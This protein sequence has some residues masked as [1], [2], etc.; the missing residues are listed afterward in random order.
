MARTVVGLD[1]GNHTVRAV[2]L[3]REGGRHTVVATAAV[4]RR[5]EAL[6]PRPMAVVLGEL[7]SLLPLG[8][9]QPVVAASDIPALVRY[10]STVPLPPD[11]LQRLLR[12]E[13][14]Q[15][16]DGAELAADTYALPVPGDE[17]IHCC[18]LAQPLQVHA[19]LADMKSAGIT[20]R[21][22]HFGTL[23]L[24]NATLPAPPVEG[25]ALAL[26]VDIGATS[27]GVVLCGERRL[28]ACRQL[29]F[30]GD[31]FTEALATAQGL[32]PASAEALKLGHQA[33]QVVPS[34]AAPGRLLEEVHGDDDMIVLDESESLFSDSPAAAAPRAVAPAAASPAA[35]T[36]ALLFEDE[37]P[38]PAPAIPVGAGRF[39]EHVIAIAEDVP[40]PAAPAVPA[41]E[42]APVL[43]APAPV[44]ASLPPVLAPGRATIADGYRALGPEMTRAAESL[45][46]QLAS[47]LA[48]FKTQL[49]LSSLSVT[50]VYLTGGGASLEGLEGYLARRFN[51]P[52]QRLDPFATLPGALPR[53]GHEFATALGLALCAADAPG[54]VGIDLVPESVVR[55]RLWST[56]LAWP[57]VAAAALVLAG[58]FYSWALISEQRANRENNEAF[59]AYQKDYD[60]LKAR[61]DALDQEKEDLSQDLRAIAGRLYAGRDL[62]NTVRALKELTRQS[63]DLWVT[64]VETLDV[65]TDAEVRDPAAP[66]TGPQRLHGAAPAAAGHKDTAIDRGAVD[67]HGLVKFD[68][69]KTD[70]ELTEFFA[71]YKDALGSWRPE[72]D[73]P[74]LFRDSR[75]I[76]IGVQHEEAT[77]GGKPSRRAKPKTAI[78]DG[79]VPFTIRLFF[80]ATELD[81]I[82]TAQPQP[83]GARAP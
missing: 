63:P 10:I 67:V 77:V 58:V 76:E 71:K 33:A 55:K 61:L 2:A 49:H 80:Q 43:A 25:D 50:R 44:P 82:S 41:A 53:H 14:Q 18:V 57:Y 36:G 28:L 48:W 47:S 21:Q 6:Q 64:R 7:D 12:L 5:D 23:A 66:T 26:V 31:A 29:A 79:R 4:A 81:Q 15:H 74:Q 27:T 73:G 8:R 19:A 11:R 75:V 40:E 13:L 1:V 45:Y 20:P 16:M 65:G 83:G 22:V 69:N 62:L 51:L 3:R 34:A 42:E 60:Q 70:V 32:P 46:T 24:F 37:D 54:A 78:V 35:F 59:A 30:G 72:P 56:R 52:V 9:S 17:I 38:A 68:K 39:D